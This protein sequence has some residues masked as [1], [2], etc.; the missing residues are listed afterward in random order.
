MK[1]AFPCFCLP[2][3]LLSVTAMGQQASNVVLH[4]SNSAQSN[5]LR[6]ALSEHEMS[7]HVFWP[8]YYQYQQESSEVEVVTANTLQAL[9]LLGDE[10][11][12]TVLVRRLLSSHRDEAKLKS[13]YFQKIQA[14]TNGSVALQF[15]QS[16]ILFELLLRSRLYE[17]N[18]WNKPKWTATMLRDDNAKLSV[19]QTAL[20]IPTPNI[21]R[22]RE[23]ADEFEFDYSRVV[24]HQF[25]FFEHCVD[26]VKEL[27]PGICKKLGLN[28]L[29]MLQDEAK[30]K[31]KYFNKLESEFGPRLAAEFISLQEY[32]FTMAKLDVWSESIA[33]QESI[34]S[35]SR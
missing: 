31:E 28:L 1:T 12:G 2:V 26:D 32:F 13:D 8:L 11:E 22:F 5:F 30:I 17:T 19:L 35:R 10:S 16:E 15:L 6:A 20:E 14:S 29:T 4:E 9:I 7:E 3:V 23:I 18:T 25:V 33:L 34:T 24:G 21:D 27:T